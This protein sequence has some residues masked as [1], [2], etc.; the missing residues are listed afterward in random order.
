MSVQTPRRSA[1]PEAIMRQEPGDVAELQVRQPPAQAVSQQTPS[2]QK[3]EA[4]SPA[5]EQV[6]PRG[7]GP[8]V[9][10]T[11]AAPVSQSESTL[12]A[13]VQAPAR[14]RNG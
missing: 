9:W 6:C 1:F 8:Q 12:H 3:P 4:H 2:T 11:Q 14:Q 10:F 7:F 5:A 13:L